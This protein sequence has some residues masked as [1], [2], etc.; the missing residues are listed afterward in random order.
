[1]SRPG[2]PLSD[3]PTFGDRPDWPDE[4]SLAISGTTAEAG[5][6]DLDAGAPAS[7]DSHN[8]AGG[9][10]LKKSATAFR[11]ISEV[12][13]ELHVPQHVLRFWETRFPQ[14]KPLKAGRWKALLPPGRCRAAAPHRRPAV[15][16]GLHHQGRAAA[17]ARWRRHPAGRSAAARGCRPGRRRAGGRGPGTAPCRTAACAARERRNGRR[18]DVAGVARATGRE[19]GVPGRAGQP[20]GR[21]RQAARGARHGAGGTREPAPAT[22]GLSGPGLSG[23][24]ARFSAHCRCSSCPALLHR[25]DRRN[26]GQ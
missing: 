23:S 9:G 2:D 21:D 24:G 6:F 22:A 20:R 25:R 5:L 13:D 8:D 14:V 17:A 15:H 26:G 4:S 19:R 12:A 3:E 10:R 1:M 16:P 11:T 7:G 18:V